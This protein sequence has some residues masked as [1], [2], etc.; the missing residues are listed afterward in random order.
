MIK[1]KI[2]GMRD[3]ANIREVGE[4]HPDYMGFIFYKK[5]PRYVGDDFV[6]PEN[7]VTEPVGVFVNE[8]KG[9]IFKRLRSINSNIAQLHGNEK[10]AECDELKSRGITVVKVFSIDD[11][12]DFGTTEQYE[13]VADYFLFDTKGKLYGGN[14]K[15]FNW[16]KLQEYNQRLP[17][18]LSGGLNAGNMN[19][20]RTLMGMNLHAVDL[21]SGVEDTPGM[22]NIERIREVMKIRNVE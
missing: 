4:L 14:A 15:A 1:V 9:E 19:G 8:E 10:P 22:K 3:A 21:N 16:E 5:S 11:D 17:F 7:S 6:L 18:F 20:L 2:C 12:F 13:D